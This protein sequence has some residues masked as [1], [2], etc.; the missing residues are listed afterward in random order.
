MLQIILF[1]D[2]LKQSQYI[3]K[4]VQKV[5]LNAPIQYY[6]FK[7][8]SQL[9]EI[10]LDTNLP[11]IFLMDI[12]LDHEDGIDS[13]SSLLEKFH[14]AVVI[15]IS[16]YLEKVTDIYETRH[17]YFIYKPELEIR[18]EKALNKAVSILNA[19]QK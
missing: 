17:C 14:H 16:A 7:N 15:F 5:N 1:E 9:F 3:Q 18:I 4:V 19:M 11:T 6:A 13:A 10:S 2:D 8:T 12:V